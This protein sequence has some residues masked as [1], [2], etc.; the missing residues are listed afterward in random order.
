MLITLIILAVT[1]ILFVSNRVRTDIVALCALVALM[2]FG[3][4]TPK[5]ALSGFSDSIIFMMLGLF[6]VGEAIFQV[7]LAQAIGARILKLAGNNRTKLF[8]F[9]VGGTAAIGGFLSNTGTIA[10]MLPIIVSMAAENNLNPSRYLMP[11]AFA[12]SM[13]GMLTLIGTPPNLIISETLANAGYGELSFFSFLPVGII[14]ITIGI[15]LLIPLSKLLV[16]NNNETVKDK[17]RKSLADIASEYNITQDLYCV[18]VTENSTLISKKLK[19][20]N[21]PHIYGISVLEIRNSANTKSVFSS[22]EVQQVPTADT[23]LVLNDVLYVLGNIK[24]IQKFAAD[25][26]LLFTETAMSEEQKATHNLNLR[27]IDIG[28]AEIVLLPESHLI[29]RTIK[30]SG[31]REKYKVSV[32]G[33]QRHSERITHNLKDEKIQTGDVLLI[34]GEWKD[35]QFLAKDNENWVIVGQP[36]KEAPK[37]QGYKAPIAA[38]IM[39]IMIVSMVLNFI[40]PVVSVLIAAILTL[41]TGCFKNVEEAYHS[42]NWNTIVLIGCMLPM[43]IALEKTG[44]I[45][46][47]TGSLVNNLG[48]YGSYALLAGIYLATQLMTMFISNTAT[49]V[50]FAPV[51][52]QAAI[53]TN[54]NPT[55]FLFAVAIAASMCFASPFATP[56]NA[57]VMSPGRYTFMDYVKVGMPLQF[58]LAI[59]MIAVLPLIFPF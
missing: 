23:I 5:E 59:V 27:F 18:Q 29:N 16:R 37:I 51:A 3:I 8:V 24:N 9:L 6:V 12:G 39:I 1:M 36:L 30:E 19:E 10:I 35:I 33:I 54:L 22:N 40:P 13:G 38:A 53:T 4:L 28:I 45:A 32:I 34:Q 58:V 2:L 55:P 47:V 41:V 15:I 49:A 52:L 57:L 21:M 43:G 46:V 20:L 31:L 14:V 11:L 25:Y 17:H 44:I 48:S 42:I 7:G 26:N 56:P 50:L